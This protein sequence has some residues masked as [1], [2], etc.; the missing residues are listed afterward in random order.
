[1]TVLLSAYGPSLLGAVVLAVLGVLLLAWQVA[2][3]QRDDA[4]RER[5]EAR[6]E[7]AGSTPEALNHHRIRHEYWMNAY[8]ERW[9]SEQVL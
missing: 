8:R 1:M 3:L 2:L 4:R 7:L 6:D 5:D 9:G